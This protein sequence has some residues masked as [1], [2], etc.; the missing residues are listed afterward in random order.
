M[1]PLPLIYFVCCSHVAGFHIGRFILRATMIIAISHGN[2]SF[3]K[4]I[5]NMRISSQR[6]AG[7]H[8]Q[9]YIDICIISHSMYQIEPNFVM[10][11]PILEISYVFKDNPINDHWPPCKVWLWY[12]VY[13]CDVEIKI[14]CKHWVNAMAAD[15]LVPCVNMHSNKA[16]LLP[17]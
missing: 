5:S 6:R 3:F 12:V 16:M 13:P 4:R 14:F 8:K 15:V 7:L 11:T 10:Y 1:L 17:M 2:V 9:R